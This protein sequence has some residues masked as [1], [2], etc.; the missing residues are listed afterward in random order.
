MIDVLI[1]QTC[2]VRGKV[3][4]DHDGEAASFAI[5][6]I[7]K[8]EQRTVCDI[9]GRFELR[10]IPI[11]KH[12]IEVECLGYVKLKQQFSATK[13]ISLKLKLQ[14]SSFALPEFEVMA[15]KSRKGKVIIDESALEYIQ[16]TSLADVMLLLPGS[17]YKENNLTQFSQ[18]SS[19]QVGSDANTSLGVG[20]ITDGA[21]VS[22]DGV[23]SQLVG[24]TE[25]S[26]SSY[27]VEMR[28]RSGIN[29]GADMRMISTDHIQSMEFTRGISSARYGN[30]SSGMISISSKHGVTPLRLR[31]KSD[32][33]NKL[34]YAG[35]GWRLGEK[36]G[37]LHTGIDY[38][39]SIDDIRDEMD[40]FSRLT[41]QL[42]YNNKI[43]LGSHA[44]DIDA[45]LSQTIT[46]SK[47]KKDEL[48]YEYDETY[49]ADYNR[50]AL[51]LKGNL[52]L[53]KAW[54]DQ[55]ELV[56]SA[57][58]TND[59]ISR[60]RMVLSG[61]GPMNI[62]LAYEEG[63]HEGIYLPRKYY[64]DFYIDNQP[65]NIYAQLNATTRIQLLKHTMLNLQ[66]GA[67]YTNV[68]NHGAGAVIEDETRPPFPYDNS[69]MRP[70]PN[71]AIPALGTGAAYA[72]A[73]FIYDDN[74]SNILQLSLGGRA[75]TLMNLP[76]DYYLHGK[77]LTDPRMNLS[78]TIGKKLKNTFR[79]GFGT[80]SKTP[81]LDYLY[82]EKLYKDFYMLNAYTNDPQY[83]HLIT[84]T[85]IFDVANR[86]LRAN[87]NRKME[88]GWDIDYGKLSLSLTAFYEQ[89]D[90]GFEYFTEYYPLTYDLYT[91]LK[92][93][94]N[95]EGRIPQ[96]SDYIQEQYSI[97]TTSQRVMNS[98][99][100][101][102]RGIEYRLILPKIKPLLTT[103][104]INGAYY[105]TDYA[106][107]LPSYYYPAVKIG[108]KEYPYVCIFDNDARN[109]Y[110]RLNS[111]IWLNTHIPKFKMFLT[112][113]FQVVC[114]NTS[115]YKDNQDF[116][117]T[118]YIDMQGNR[119][120][121]DDGI[122]NLIAD[123]DGIFRYF[124][125]TILPVKYARDENPISLL[126]NMKATKEFKKGT[127][128]SFFVN[129]LLDISPKYLSGS[130]VTKREWHD[131]YFGLEL[132]LNLNL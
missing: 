59:R 47:M 102:K 55:L 108:G 126:W 33:K 132:Y 103:V 35:K 118:E 10:N 37:T 44:L 29:Q 88:A 86:D 82:P 30:L 73:D 123:D 45:R 119:L 93:G 3:I 74:N 39:H 62:P 13:D 122:R 53:C 52:T 95:I 11:G 15:K 85:N 43:Q 42:Y 129:G 107:S 78:Y 89:S 41:G 84:Y 34:I 18:I 60:H 87:K 20:I 114:L 49:K 79:I 111:N 70:R 6:S 22:N 16:P 51:M 80:E 63:E 12:T 125:R 58:Y 46:M 91:T 66:Y 77:I 14:S 68:K 100:V 96:K 120:P 67:E 56:L 7:Q 81:T 124:R 24:I 23:R 98:K 128:L 19:R 90:A 26:G 116:I 64:S 71:W 99:K 5:V 25:G 105:Q 38:L 50:T 76:H 101:T 9:D 54:M 32:L 92:P 110:R 113:F 40:K 127:K 75:S 31:L 121:V 8:L 131:P 115:Q 72:Q 94:V 17:V 65:V 28:S 61:S 48:T 21:P 106:S 36:A 112:N 117:P 2:T 27:D 1:A 130:K 4:T 97:F 109:Q 104:E 57:D 83:R 69:Y